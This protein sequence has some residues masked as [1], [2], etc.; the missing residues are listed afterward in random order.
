MVNRTLSPTSER[1]IF[2]LFFQ[3]LQGFEQNDTLAIFVFD[4]IEDITAVQSYEA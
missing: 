3:V 1:F 4:E 2:F